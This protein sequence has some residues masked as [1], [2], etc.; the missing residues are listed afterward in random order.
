M[1]ARN[2]QRTCSS[3]GQ[4][5]LKSS[6]SVVLSSETVDRCKRYAEQ[7]PREPPV[8]LRL[9]ST[10]VL[11]TETVLWWGTDATLTVIYYYLDA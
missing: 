8:P 11:F 3:F 5:L 4:T 10:V 6:F 9:R 7:R 2:R 1:D